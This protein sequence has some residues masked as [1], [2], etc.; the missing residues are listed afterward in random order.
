MTA[1]WSAIS[2]TTTV[3]GHAKIGFVAAA[4]A[5]DTLSLVLMA[6]RWRLLLRRLGSGARLWE[7]LVA[8]SAGVCVSNITP[9]R[10]LGGDA[11]RAALIR[12]PGGSPPVKAIVASV[13]YDRATDVPGLLLLGVLALPVLKPKSPDIVHWGLLALF[14]LTAVLVARSLYPRLISRIRQRYQTMM[15]SEV[16]TSVAAAV[17]CSLMIWSLDVTRIMLVGGAF[18]VR[19]VPSQAAAISLLR[20]GSGLMPVP[21]GI[22]VVDGALVAGFI[23]LGLPPATAAALALVERAIV[24]AWGT[25]LGAA[26]LLLLGG[27]RALKKALTERPLS[28]PMQVPD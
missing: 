18:G 2:A 20:L 12:R 24:Y 16:G 8:Y 11:C 23:W 22:G 15:S 19:F 28:P 14:A 4:F 25:A 1:L 9:A 5:V 21:A 6:F 10:T 13:V 7:T 17:G 3:I 27:S 26:A